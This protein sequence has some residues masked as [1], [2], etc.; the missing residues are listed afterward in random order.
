MCWGSVGHHR[1]RRWP[2]LPVPL[3]VPCLL[4]LQGVT[5]RMAGGCRGAPGCL[6]SLLPAQAATGALPAAFRQ[7]G[8]G[9]LDNARPLALKI[10]AKQL[11]PLGACSWMRVGSGSRG[12]ER[13]ERTVGGPSCR[14]ASPPNSSGTHPAASVVLR[15]GCGSVPRGGCR[16]AHLSRLP[17]PPAALGFFSAPF[18][19]G[20]SC[21]LIVFGNKLLVPALGS[22]GAQNSCF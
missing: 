13:R 19:R 22:P 5:G 9:G 4:A 7:H 11:F 14:G 3:P 10:H 2:L 15:G 1:E 18:A 16:D 12:A 6:P 21:C 17:R 20:W 8:E